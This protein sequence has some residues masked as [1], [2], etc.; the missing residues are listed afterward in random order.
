MATIASL[1]TEIV[2][3][4]LSYL[5]IQSL[6]SFSATSKD[7]Q[8]QARY[9]LLRLDLAV[10]PRQVHCSLALASQY[11]RDEVQGDIDPP[12]FGI[13]KIT[14]V[15]LALNKENPNP[16]TIRQIQIQAQNQIATDILTQQSVQNLQSLTLHMYDVQSGDLADTIGRKLPHLRNLELNFCHPFIHNSATSSSYWRHASE[17]TPCWNSL[18]GLG[19]ENQRHLHL[20]NLQSL[21]VDRASALN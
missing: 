6:L 16:A 17:G 5:N 19:V 20:Q 2:G 9:S 14:H 18:V 12:Q 15:S 3:S 4:I 13:G 10:L 11:C 7:N 21:K 1:P 8:L